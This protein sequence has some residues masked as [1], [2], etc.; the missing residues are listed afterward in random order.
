M[1]ELILKNSHQPISQDD[2][3]LTRAYD[4]RDTVTFSLSRRDPAVPLLRERARVLETTTGQLFLVSGVDGGQTQADFVLKKDLTDWTSVAYPGYTNGSKTATAAQTITQIL[5]AGWSLTI[6]EENHLQAYLSLEGPTPLDVAL[7]CM[8]V[9][10]CALEFDNQRKIA[11]LHFPG[12]KAL[13]T[14]FLAEAANLRAAPEYKSAAG[15]MV[16]RLYAQGAGGVDFADINDGKPY[17]ECFAG[18]EE[19]L[20]GFWRDDR[21]TV[22]EH[23]LAAARE[24]IKSLSQPERSWSLWVCDLKGVDGAAWPGLEL[25]LYDVLR[26]VDPSLGQT[27]EAQITELRLSPH[28]PEKNQISITNVTGTLRPTLSA[29]L[30]ERSRGSLYGDLVV[31]VDQVKKR[32]QDTDDLAAAAQNRA[33][34]AQA[35]ADTAQNTADTAQA[36]ADTAQAAADTAQNTADTA[37]AAAL[38]IAGGT[39]AGGTFL[40][41]KRLYSP[42]IYGKTITLRSTDTDSGAFPTLSLYPASGEP[43]VELLASGNSRQ[44]YSAALTSPQDL[45]LSSDCA[46]LLH[47]GEGTGASGESGVSVSGALTA[48]GLKIGAQSMADFVTDQGVS[49][50]WRYR[51]WASGIRECWGQSSAQRD[52]SQGWQD[53]GYISPYIVEQFPF[54]FSSRPAVTVSCCNDSIVTPALGGSTGPSAVYFYLQSAAATSGTWSYSI[55]AIGE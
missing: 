48:T 23:L 9:Y 20:A 43:M 25:G 4:G 2:Y 30:V 21:Y 8:E 37:Q 6:E 39:Y 41:G 42:E 51:K 24:K 3:V 40:D 53:R 1:L 27:M 14:A 34:T 45:V 10:G 22:P 35:A 52:I 55:Y 38:A 28:H 12:Q 33:D 15:D 50:I 36:A 19:V 5:P 29:S 54:S 13:G 47:P 31:T 26:L 17:V 16:T 32:L 49:G 46:I 11:H 44:G 18:C 7:H